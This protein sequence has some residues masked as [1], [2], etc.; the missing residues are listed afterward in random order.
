M[1]ARSG[2]PTPADSRSHRSATESACIHVKQDSA[3]RLRSGADEQGATE[4]SERKNGDGDQLGPRQ[5]EDTDGVSMPTEAT[6]S[7]GDD[8]AASSEA[9]GA[10]SLA[11]ETPDATEIEETEETEETEEDAPTSLVEQDDADDAGVGDTAGNQVSPGSPYLS[12]SAFKD[13]GLSFRDRVARRLHEQ[14]GMDISTADRDADSGQGGDEDAQNEPPTTAMSLDTGTPADTGIADTEAQDS[15]A[16]DS[17]AADTDAPADPAVTPTAGSAV[18][19][20]STRGWFDPKPDTRPFHAVAD[21]PDTGNE[22]VEEPAAQANIDHATATAAMNPT[23]IEPGGVEPSGQGSQDSTDGFSAANEAPTNTTTVPDP[24]QEVPVVDTTDRDQGAEELAESPGPPHSAPSGE[25]YSDVPPPLGNAPED[26]EA[27]DTEAQDTAV[28]AA[29]AGP[30]MVP[31]SGPP[32]PPPGGVVPPGEP[33]GTE[34]AGGGD[35]LAAQQGVVAH[36]TEHDS[37]EAAQQAD[38]AT[39]QKEPGQKRPLWFRITRGALIGAGVLVLLAG[40]TFAAAYAIIDIPDDTQAYATDQKST[41]YYAD[42]ETVL[43]E[44]GVNRDPVELDEVPEEVQNAVLSAEDRDF[45]D[46]PGV[47]ASGTMRG[48][49]NTV[50]GQQVQGGSTVTQ[51]L[52]RNYYEGLSQEQTI[53]RKFREIIIALKVDRQEAPGGYGDNKEWVLEQYLN[54]VYFG[55]GA[56]GIEAAAQAYYHKGVDELSPDEAAFLAAAI[57]NPSPFGAADVETATWM[58]DRWNYVVNGLVDMESITEAE[59]GD[60]EFAEPEPERSD[61]DTNMAGFQ[62]YM[63]QQA[64]AEL[65]ELGFTEDDIQRGA[66]SIRTTFDEDLMQVAEESV[67]AHVDLDTVPEGV[68]IGIAAIEPESG[69]VAAFYGGEDYL[70]NAYDSAFRGSAQ[71]G[72]AFKPYVLAAA[73]ESGLSLNTVVDGSGPMSI[74]GA[75]ISNATGDNP[76]VTLTQ[77]TEDS[78]NTGFV[79]LGQQVGLDSVVDLAYAS[80]IPENMIT[81]DQEHAATLPL[82]VS[83][84]SPMH[85]ATGYATFAN[86]GEYVEPHVISEIENRDGEDERPEIERSQ[87]VS[88]ETAADVT[89]AMEQVISSGTGTRASIGRPAAGKTGTTDGSVAAWFVGYTPQLATSVGV[90]NGDNQSF[91]MP[92]YGSLSGGTLPAMIWQTFMSRAMEGEEVQQFP[93]PAMDGNVQDWGGTPEPT[94]EPDDDDEAP[95]NGEDEATEEPEQDEPEEEPDPEEPGIPEDPEDPEDPGD[96][97]PGDPEDP[98]NGD[99]GN[100]SE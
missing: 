9:P 55:R 94:R 54:T 15:D 73:L 64:I 88:P 45:W 90:F 62:G 26:T 4:L 89:H 25:P 68:E 6:E 96:T 3:T 52:V 72:S 40:G 46:E 44:R 24:T 53:N 65:E 20:Q 97:D 38:A 1:G 92:G 43:A 47:S 80:G 75:T 35:S 67:E 21:G 37:D 8:A 23:D 7:A 13:T 48:I 36:V 63:V 16:Q 34:P 41:F 60:M 93:D 14:F 99:E 91:S 57:Q 83:D 66:Y 56:Y 85:Q 30:A 69:E 84:V 98:G 27:Q 31:P 77:A 29:A 95:D 18:A 81:E 51:Q 87:A 61:E 100:D 22:S 74:D 11:A 70:E 42:G 59:A 28:A 50:T 19:G 79:R 2:S 32:V 5:D 78:S 12:D 82:G 33:P 39:D 10:E 49:W 76:R 71:A 17:E 58:E 86:G